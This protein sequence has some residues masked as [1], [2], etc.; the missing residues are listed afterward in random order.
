MKPKEIREL[1]PEEISKKLREGREAL[2]N[3]RLRK[4]ASQI[5]KSSEL[6]RLRREIARLETILKE[7]TDA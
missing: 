2:L 5:E 3:L 7:K 6:R 1:S 4:Q